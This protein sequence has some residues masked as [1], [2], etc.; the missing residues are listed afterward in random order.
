M[1][2][3]F[4]LIAQSLNF[5]MGCFIY[6]CIGTI[7]K[8][9]IYFKRCVIATLFLQLYISNLPD[10]I[11][12]KWYQLMEWTLTA[13][14]MSGLSLSTEGCPSGGGVNHGSHRTMIL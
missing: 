11:G 13:T 5:L 9:V 6:A 1:F 10:G 2:F 8:P 7:S 12:N 14:I 3:V 4:T